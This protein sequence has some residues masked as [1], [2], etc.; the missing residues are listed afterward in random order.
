MNKVLNIY[1][2]IGL[3]PFQ[4]IQNL[5]LLKSEYKYIKIGFAGRLDPLAHGVMLLMVGDE[6][7]NRNKYLGLSKEYEFEVL[8]GL[9]SDTYDVMGILQ[10]KLINK[11]PDNLQEQ[12]KTYIKDKIGKNIQ[13]YPPFSSK[14]VNGK[15]LF[16]LAKKDKLKN[17]EIPS[18]EI[19]I[20][21]F[22]F[23]KFKKVEIGQIEKLVTTNINLVKGDFR[24]K[25]IIAKWNQ[26]FKKNSSKI[27]SIAKFR[28]HCSSGTYVRSLANEMGN[29]FNSGGI[30]IS[31]CRTRVGRYKIEDSIKLKS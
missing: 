15:P 14:T 21:K 29:I 3:T 16:E 4:L 2:P 23:L 24:Q 1:K 26:F 30:A 31:I 18:R 28:I 19:E 10:S 25:E 11:N 5:R 9:S 27:F 13:F 20:Y 12:I 6:T 17:I 22:E 8:Y 7:K